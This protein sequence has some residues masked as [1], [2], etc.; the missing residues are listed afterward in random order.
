MNVYKD[1]FVVWDAATF[2]TDDVVPVFTV[3]VVVGE[4]KAVTTTVLVRKQAVAAGTNF[5]MQ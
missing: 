1:A 3:V 4:E 5:M 2:N